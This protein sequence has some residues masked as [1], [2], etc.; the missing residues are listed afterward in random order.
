MKLDFFSPGETADRLS[1]QLPRCSL[2]S[3]T[4]RL[5]DV[6]LCRPVFLEPVPCCSV[7]RESLRDGFQ[8][9]VPEALAQHRALEK[10]LMQNGV[11]CHFLTPQ[12]GMPDMCFT[13][14][15]LLTT[16]WGLLALKPAA[17]HRQTEADY[18]LRALRQLGAPLAARIR[19]GTAEGGDIS[20]VRR[21]LVIIGCSGARTDD[22]GADSAAE[23]FR[24][25]GWDVLIYRFDPHFLHLDTQ[26]AM[27]GDGLALACTD[28]LSEDFLAAL[29]R[30]RIDIIPVS[31]KESRKLGCNVLS[32][33]DRRVLAAKDNERVNAILRARGYTVEAIELDQFTRCGGGVHCLTM[34]LA[35]SAG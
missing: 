3:E 21:G 23:V 35:R 33:G 24:G 28:V 2:W 6:L 25:Q 9:S 12:E 27:V 5:T 32:L 17:S 31:Y 4:D 8:T 29:D 30:H 11:R 26:L 16:P 34:P 14:D 10:A 1:P 18:A 22:E 13:R 20:I 15:A 7:T 19:R